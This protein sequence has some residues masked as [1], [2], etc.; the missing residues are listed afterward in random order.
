MPAKSLILSA[1]LGCQ[2][3]AAGGNAEQD[4]AWGVGT[5]EGGLLDDLV[6]DAGNGPT[7]RP[8]RSSIP[9]RC[10]KSRWRPRALTSFSASL[11]GSLKD[12]E[13]PGSL[14]PVAE[15]PVSDT[16]GSAQAGLYD[17][18]RTRR[19]GVHSVFCA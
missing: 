19:R 14:T 1:I 12:V 10:Q 8:P 7:R 2:R 17:L 16:G 13:L 6:S 15:P 18:R 5:V 3:D 11:D 9:G 4:D